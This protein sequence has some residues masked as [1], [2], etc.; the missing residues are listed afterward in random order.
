MFLSPKYRFGDKWYTI[1]GQIQEAAAPETLKSGM[2]A[3]WTNAHIPDLIRSGIY[4]K[5][6]VEQMKTAIYDTSMQRSATTYLKHLLEGRH[7][8]STA[9][10]IENMIPDSVVEGTVQRYWLK[11][12]GFASWVG[13]FTTAVI[14]FYMIGKLIKFLIDTVIHGK[15]LYDLYGL[16]W[17]LVAAFW[18]SLTT[19]FTHR[20]MSHR[21]KPTPDVVGPT[22]PTDSPETAEL[23][24]R[25]TIYPVLP[26][27]TAQLNLHHSQRGSH[28]MIPECCTFN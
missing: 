2:R 1:D 7:V 14:G 11:F 6:Q 21:E 20:A 5:D 16:G 15:I 28:E 27:V 4:T 9:F 25:V 17:Q 22:A 8:S 18:D 3:N 26:T 24:D 13:H 23:L 10:D 12:L 19:F